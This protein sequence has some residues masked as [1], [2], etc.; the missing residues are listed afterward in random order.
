MYPVEFL[1]RI[2][3]PGLSP[4]R[5]NLKSNMAQN[6]DPANGLCNGTRLICRRLLPRLIEAEILTGKFKGNIVFLPRISLYTADSY[7]VPAPIPCQ[8]LLRNDHQQVARPNC[9]QTRCLL[10]DISVSHGQLYVALLRCKYQK[11]IYVAIL[12]DEIPGHPG[13]YTRNIVYRNSL[14]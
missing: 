3:Q 14:T 1:N 2:T 12:G 7:P 6:I 10:A 4:H 5:L 8:D 9:E 11:S 13:L